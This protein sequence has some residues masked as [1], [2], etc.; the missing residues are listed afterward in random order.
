M[1]KRTLTEVLSE[2]LSLEKEGVARLLDSFRDVVASCGRELDSVSI[3]AFGTFESKKRL[4]RIAMHPATGK[5]ILI[6]PKIVL[7]F[8][9]SAILKQKVN[10]GIGDER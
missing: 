8:K 5:R 7:T 9:P 10:K 6:P 2:K 1:D 4:E 3:P